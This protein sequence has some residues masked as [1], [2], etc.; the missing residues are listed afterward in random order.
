MFQ[1]LEFQAIGTEGAKALRQMD[2]LA[3][4]ENS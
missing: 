2:H 4:L 1:V 3:E